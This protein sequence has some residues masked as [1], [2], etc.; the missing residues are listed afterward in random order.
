M[1]Y[2]YNITKVQSALKKVFSN[3]F[4]I[5]RESITAKMVLYG[6]NTFD[7]IRR[8]AVYNFIHRTENSENSLLNIL[9]NSLYFRKCCLSTYWQTILYTCN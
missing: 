6:C 1:F 5:K 3:F 2:I 8:K 4:N 7:M 9:Y